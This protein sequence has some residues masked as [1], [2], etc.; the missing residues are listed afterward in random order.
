MKRAIT[1]CLLSLAYFTANAQVFG[2]PG[3]TWWYLKQNNEENGIFKYT[4]EGSDSTGKYQYIDVTGRVFPID[5]DLPWTPSFHYTFYISGDSVFLY[6]YGKKYL[7]YYFNANIG[8]IIPLNIQSCNNNI[9]GY[10]YLKVENK[11]D[12][13]ILGNTLRAL[14]VRKYNCEIPNF[15]SN[16][17]IEKIGVIDNIFSPLYWPVG[18]SNVYNFFDMELICFTSDQLPLM[19]SDIDDCNQILVSIDDSKIN[20]ISIYPIPSSGQIL[21]SGIK[22]QTINYILYNSQGQ[23]VQSGKLNDNTIDITDKPAGMYLLNIHSPAYSK[24]FKAV[25]Q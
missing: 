4:Y 22:D 3:A 19:Q 6:S 16:L 18:N 12:T 24:S 25:K 2:G 20:N 11:F 17:I 14:V 5:G 10:S 1:I 9:L 21:V 23:Q 8:D 15:K 13:L 7:Q